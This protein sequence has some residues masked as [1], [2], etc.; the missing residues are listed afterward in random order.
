MGSAIGDI[1]PLALGVAIIAV[2]LMLLSPKA[3]TSG[4]AFLA[5]WVV[6][7]VI[8]GAAVL[9]LS[10]SV[11]FGAGGGEG[12]IVG[13]LLKIVLGLILLWLAF[14]EWRKL[15]RPGEQRPLP[16][17]MRAI[18]SVTM[19]KALGLGALLSAINPKNLS[20]TAA[21]AITIAQKGLSAGGAAFALIVFLASLS[22]APP[23]VLY[24]TGGSSARPHSTGSG[25]G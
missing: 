14:R 6:G 2:I 25:R 20:L 12:S 10:Y 1:L 23:V 18:D 8:A 9:A 16:G 21:A 19:A 5:G 11:G 4:L 24:L 15:P 17:W 13:S 7:L 22:I 3:R